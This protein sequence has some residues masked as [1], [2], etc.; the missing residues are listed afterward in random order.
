LPGLR[1]GS[2]GC[3]EVE[4]VEAGASFDSASSSLCGEVAR[5]GEYTPEY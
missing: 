5:L 1:A 2:N 4:V 3:E